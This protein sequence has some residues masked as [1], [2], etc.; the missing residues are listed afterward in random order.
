MDRRQK[1]K[2]RLQVRVQ[3]EW[4]V[5]IETRAKRRKTGLNMRVGEKG[6]RKQKKVEI[7]KRRGKKKRERMEK[8]GLYILVIE[9][10]RAKMEQWKLTTRNHIYIHQS[11]KTGR[12]TEHGGN[13]KRGWTEGSREKEDYIIRVKEEWPLGIE[14]RTKRRKTGLYKR[15]REKWKRKQK[16]VETVNEDEQKEEEGK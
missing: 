11:W 9:K 12:S 2:T 7:A 10:W 5:E 8:T 13:Q 1:R 16:K 6:K 15:L 3:E 4:R 14:T